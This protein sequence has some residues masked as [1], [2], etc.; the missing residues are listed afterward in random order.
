MT[1]DTLWSEKNGQKGWMNMDKYTITP[2]ITSMKDAFSVQG[3]NVVI[4]GGNTGI[5][6]GIVQAFAESG[7]NIA[8][9]NRRKE[10]GLQAIE[11]I[12]DLGGTYL[13]VA[14]D[15]S[16]MEC[17]KKAKEEVF[18]VFDHVDVLVN[19]AGVSM[20]GK[21]LDDTDMSEW[22]RVLDTDLHGIANMIKVFGQP[23]A[24]AGLGGSIINVSSVGGLIVG[25]S[26]THP[27]AP[28]NTAKAGVNH[29]TRYM[30]VE[31]G[32][33]GIR[34]N[35]IAPGLTH[36]NLDKDLPQSKL[37]MLT[38]DVPMH[39]FAEPIETGA[40]AVFLASPAACQITGQICVHD[41]GIQLL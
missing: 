24:E 28:Y 14:C 27:K 30:A 25:T 38:N 16:D 36:S 12:K 19:N 21:F 35:A 41:G 26:R 5:G 29:F 9:L 6:R 22:H 2:P 13:A 17:V 1:A 23:M 20:V 40:L 37:D 31:L 10:S 18:K 33:Y 4:T 3:K 7:A 32:D 39:R 15:V 8:I 34:V 11:E